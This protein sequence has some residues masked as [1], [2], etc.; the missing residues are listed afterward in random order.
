M[1]FGF[2]RGKGGTYGYFFCLGRHT[3]RTN[4]DLP[5]VPVEK[6]EQAVERIWQTDVQLA[7]PDITETRVIARS[8]LHKQCASSHLLAKQQQAR[9]KDLEHTKQKLI[10]AYLLDILPAEDIRARQTQVAKEIADAR[11]LIAQ[12]GDDETVLLGRLER[13]LTLARIAGR[14]YQHA[15]GE[16]KKWLNLAVFTTI[17]VDVADEDGQTATTS[18][19]EATVAVIG[20]VTGPVTAVYALA[21]LNRQNAPQIAPGRRQVADLVENPDHKR[22]LGKHLL[23]EGSNL[24]NLAAPMR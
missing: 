15:T 6:A 22:T 1:G 19:P 20:T 3:G 18:T 5:Y 2:S 12:A 9:L 4:C 16:A 13:I 10:D 11:A 14:L 21:D 8:D 24:C 23:A 7:E 17:S